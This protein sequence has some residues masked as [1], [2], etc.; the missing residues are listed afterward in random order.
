MK[1]SIEAKV[2]RDPL[3]PKGYRLTTRENGRLYRDSAFTDPSTMLSVVSQELGDSLGRAQNLKN[4][5]LWLAGGGVGV[6]FPTLVEAHMLYGANNLPA[7]ESSAILNFGFVPFAIYAVGLFAL[8]GLIGKFAREN[9]LNS[10]A[11]SQKEVEAVQTLFPSPDA[12][13]VTAIRG[14]RYSY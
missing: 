1:Q 9:A 5:A 14:N 13:P 7:V 8:S 3:D 11:I 12:T 6:A 4:T 2:R 10:A